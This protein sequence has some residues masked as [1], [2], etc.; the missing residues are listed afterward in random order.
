MALCAFHYVHVLHYGA[1]SLTSVR[2]SP[3]PCGMQANPIGG[4]LC[5]CRTRAMKSL[6]ALGCVCRE[7]HELVE[8]VV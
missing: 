3:P 5:F 1:H 2:S 6:Y 4:S 7:T 8:A